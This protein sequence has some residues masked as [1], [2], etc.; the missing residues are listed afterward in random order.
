MKSVRI[1]IFT[2]APQPGVAKTR[3]IPA[4]GADG[5]AALAQHM[6]QHSLQQALAAQTGAVE[7]CVTPPQNDALW[8]SVILPDALVCTDQG[9]GDLGER[10]ARAA[11]RVLAQGEPVLLIGTDC[12]A[13]DAPRLQQAA[14]A[15]QDVDAVLVPATDG[16][17]VLLGLKRFD[18]SVF[19]HMPWSSSHVASITL[20]R[21]Q[22]L[23][24]SVQCFDA[25]HD[26][27]EAA[28]LPWL[29]A[30]WRK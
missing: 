14:Q 1:V 28:D 11:S 24:W 15:L 6:L 13:L 17:Y 23:G 19:E 10:M 26:I 4:L 12:P 22:Q 2:K 3:L 8:Q 30:G 21:L 20:Q 25:L 27:D 5:A 29:P 7:L 9:E 16:G 18:A